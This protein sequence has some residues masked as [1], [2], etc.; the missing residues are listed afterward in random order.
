MIT[1]ATSTWEEGGVTRPR[2]AV[3]QDGARLHYAVPR[4][5]KAAGILEMMFTEWYVHPR[6]WTS[7]AAWLTAK[8]RPGLGRR[9]RERCHPDLAGTRI[10]TN[11]GLVLRQ[12]IAR[13]MHPLIESYYAWSSERVGAWIRRHGLGYS[14]ALFGFVRNID[15]ALCEAARQSG[16]YVVVDQMIA[17]MAEEE[18]QAQLQIERWPGWQAKIPFAGRAIVRRVEERTWAASDHITC[19]SEYVRRELVEQGVSLDRISVAPYPV[20][21][22]NYSFADR[23]GRSANGAPPIVGFVG[24]VGLRKG[25]PWFF[26]VA[27]RF[28]PGQARFVMV[29]PIHL[30]PGVAD[31]HKGDVELV[32]AV[33]RSEVIRWLERFDILL[34]PSTCEGSPTAVAEAM[35]SGLPVVSTPNSGTFLREE[36]D[37][38][39]RP[40][41]DVDGLAEA[42]DRLVSDAALRVEM[43]RQ[44]R[45]R[46]ETFTLAAYSE[47]LATIYTRLMQQ[48]YGRE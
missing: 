16:L 43:G 45:E 25:A 23:R 30:Q 13:K 24:A 32:G 4:A 44:A 42:V 26:E 20:D 29:G 17:P 9:M 41:D 21:A 39:I 14:S 3:I 15:P 33:P 27:R 6:S 28:G 8:V 35:A 10:I 37:G 36:Q 7:L 38:F 47:S 11:P 34:F 18:R 2:V 48:R 1:L 5:L 40:Y 22:T 12:E 46:A 31:R 19:A